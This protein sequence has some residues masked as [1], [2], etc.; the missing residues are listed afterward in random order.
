M[1][2]VEEYCWTVDAKTLE[3]VTDQFVLKCKDFIEQLEV[4][5]GLTINTYKGPKSNPELADDLVAIHESFKNI[6]GHFEALDY[7]MRFRQRRDAARWSVIVR[8]NGDRLRRA[9][10]TWTDL[11]KRYKKFFED[12]QMCYL[13]TY[14]KNCREYHLCPDDLGIPRWKFLN[15]TK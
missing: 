13:S 14:C 8:E 1:K 6:A 4:Y 11:K 7:L 10:K 3:I 5:K 9:R 12:W 2:V 15:K